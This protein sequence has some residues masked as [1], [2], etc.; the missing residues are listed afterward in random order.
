MWAG[1]LDRRRADPAG[2]CGNRGGQDPTR[3]PRANCLA[4]RFVLAVYNVDRQVLIFEECR[5]RSVLARYAVHYDRQRPYRALLLRPQRSGAERTLADVVAGEAA[6][7]EWRP[8]EGPVAVSLGV[9][10]RSGIAAAGTRRRA[11]RARTWWGASDQVGANRWTAR[12][13]GVALRRD[14]LFQRPRR[15]RDLS[16]LPKHDLQPAT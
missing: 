7:T 2:R 10:G 14:P 5:L 16:P 3:R 13:A 15:P 4:E 6:V 8:L 1:R 12:T 9:C 11:A